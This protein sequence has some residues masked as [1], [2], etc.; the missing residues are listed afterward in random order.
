MDPAGGS[1]YNGVYTWRL[2]SAALQ[3]GP[4][5]LKATGVEMS[6]QGSDFVEIV[7]GVVSPALVRCAHGPLG[8]RPRCTPCDV[9]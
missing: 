5:T 8:P 2:D 3:R 1:A 7:V 6:L 9:A 4:S